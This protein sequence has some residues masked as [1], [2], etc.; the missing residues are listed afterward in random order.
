MRVYKVG[1]ILGDAHFNAARTLRV[2]ARNVAGAVIEAKQTAVRNMQK[3]ADRE[4]HSTSV[5]RKI[6][7]TG[8]VEET[9]VEPICDIDGISEDLK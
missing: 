2:V 3:V 7:E 4:D 1:L 8:L 9:S 5:Y 6:L